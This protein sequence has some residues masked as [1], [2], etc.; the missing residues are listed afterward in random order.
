V[1]TISID[2]QAVAAKYGQTSADNARAM[3]ESGV[4]PLIIRELD[5]WTG[6]VH[7][8]FGL[9]APTG[10]V[11]INTV[12]TDAEVAAAQTAY[13][14]YI[15]TYAKVA[16]TTQIGITPTSLAPASLTQ[17]EAKG[18][19][20]G[21]KTIAEQVKAV[22]LGATG[23]SEL[24]WDEW[25]YYWK[26]VVGSD[27]PA[28]EDRG[29]V[30]TAAGAVIIG[31]QA[32]YPFETWYNS[33]FG[34]VRGPGTAAVPTIGG[35]GIVPAIGGAG[36]YGTGTLTGAAGGSGGAGGGS[37]GAGYVGGGG[38]S[39]PAG[40]ATISA[41]KVVGMPAFLLGELI[42]KLSPG[43]DKGKATAI[44]GG[45]LIAAGLLAPIQPIVKWTLIGSGAV[46][47]YA[48]SLSFG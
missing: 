19:P 18:D 28:P 6:A 33:A 11:N 40:E 30:R 25:N 36:M 26:Q 41:L 20:V 3:V 24:S 45:L 37:G 14:N 4:S 10:N 47:V 17:P 7:Y 12:R 42:A 32:R 23:R 9:P 29:W 38:V 34:S 5:Q 15:D 8:E 43:M 1:S 13:Q 22:A 48:G 27:G 16:T 21:T 44:A 2:W 35:A 39:T 46:G 31:G